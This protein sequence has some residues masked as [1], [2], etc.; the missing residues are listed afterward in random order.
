[1]ETLRLTA[2]RAGERADAF[3]AR[4]VPG[5]TRSAA[6]RLLEEGAVTL[7]GRPVKKNYKTAPGNVLEAVLPDPEP[8][9]ILPQ[10]IP[11]DVVYEDADV[12]VVNK[13]VGL[14][15]HP[16][17]GHPDGTLVNA[18]L[19]HCGDSLSGINGELRPGIVHRIDRDT[20]GLIIAAKNDKA[21]LAL[22]AQLQD[23]SLARV[24]E[25]VAV[26]NLRE[27]A[28]TVD[29]PIGRHPVDRKK[30]AID[31]KNG[32]PAVTH[33]SV[34]GRYPGYTHVECRLETGRTHQIRVH[35]AS[36][37]HPLLGDVV[38]GSKKPWP[39]LAG[40]CL[41]ARKLRFVHPS[42]GKPV[43]LECPLP[44]WFEKVLKQIDK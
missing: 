8:V 24:Y 18:L 25:A 28:G 14:V 33:W 4:C 35:L 5:L 38:Y 15:V 44:D 2:D 42:T 6:Q 29:A 7:G 22:A 20:S 39:G 34:L 36:I 3:L 21:H 9:A 41:H 13:P 37:G 43:E 1:M 11:L 32:R 26:G 31:R 16:A 10:N 40:Q 19:Y 23:H 17:P 30:M 27:D 12:I